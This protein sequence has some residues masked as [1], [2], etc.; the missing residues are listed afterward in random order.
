MLRAIAKLIDSKLDGYYV[1]VQDI[2]LWKPTVTGLCW[3]SNKAIVALCIEAF[4]NQFEYRGI[5]QNLTLRLADLALTLNGQ[6]VVVIKNRYG[7]KMELYLAD[8]DFLDRLDELL[9]PFRIVS[10]TS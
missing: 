9:E 10:C 8:P 7:P 1:S 4:P 6:K 2:G 3:V 5:D